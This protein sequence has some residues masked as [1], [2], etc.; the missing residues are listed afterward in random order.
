M[1]L[2]LHIIRLILLSFCCKEESSDKSQ[3]AGQ[4]KHAMSKKHTTNSS[5]QTRVAPLR[6]DF[7]V[8]TLSVESLVGAVHKGSVYRGRN[9]ASQHAA[10]QVDQSDHAP[11]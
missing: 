6:C 2:V 11:V 1:V 10:T 4:K 5:R 8:P 9:T 7:G 3:R